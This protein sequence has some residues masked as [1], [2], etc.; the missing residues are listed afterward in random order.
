MGRDESRWS[1]VAPVWLAVLVVVL[2]PRLALASGELDWGHLDP[3]HVVTFRSG[4]TP[5]DRFGMPHD[6]IKGYLRK[7]E[8]SGPFPA[9]VLVHGSLGIFEF[10]RRWADRLA[11]LGYVAML[12][13]SRGR[14]P[15]PTVVTRA[16]DDYGALGYLQRQPYVDAQRVVAIGW[17]IGGTAVMTALRA[18]RPGRLEPQDE[19]TGDT[20]LRFQAG[21]AFYPNCSGTPAPKYAP[22]LILMGAGDR[23]FSPGDCE[24]LGRGDSAGGKPVQVKLYP[25]ATHLFDKEGKEQDAFGNPTEYDST[26]DKDAGERIRAFLAETL[27]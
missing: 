5:T 15:E 20:G 23:Y 14:N 21:V 3:A 4:L 1:V 22:L 9:V 8:G 19:Y 2:A 10:E 17:E 24:A 25:G 18:A 6:Q 16:Q 27:H 7:P 13:N 12:V 11:K 26:A